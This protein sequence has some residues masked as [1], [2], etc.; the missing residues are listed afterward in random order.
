MIYILYMLALFSV[1]SVQ[2][3]TPADY[4]NS[5]T[6]IEDPFKL[7]DPFKPP[8]I[9]KVE[10]TQKGEG[11]MRDG[12]F[13]NMISAEDVNLEMLK[14]VGVMVGKE[15]RAVG[16]IGDK[17]ETFVLR[18]GMKIGSDKIELKAILPGGVV[19]VEK[20]TNVYGQDE[21]LETVVP[22]SQE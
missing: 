20:I 15:R 6:K 17:G 5:I 13:T 19:F 16:K 14:V 12:I 3:Q 7:R 1:G 18:E 21:Y 8:K 2:A 4:I 10:A 22:L 9:K 11:F